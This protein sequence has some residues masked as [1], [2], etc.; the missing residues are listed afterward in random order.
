MSILGVVT[1]NPQ[2]VFSSRAT[3]TVSVVVSDPSIRR[4]LEAAI[5]D[6]GWQVETF[7]SAQEY[8]ARQCFTGPSCVILEVSLL[9]F[10]LLKRLADRANTRAILINGSG[11]VMSVHDMKM[12]EP[13]ESHRVLSAVRDAME[14]SERAVRREQQIEALRVCYDSLSA[15]EREVMALVVEGLLNKQVGHKLGLSEITVKA[16]R[17]KVMRKMKAPSL[18]ELVRMAAWLELSPGQPAPEALP[19]CRGAARS[20]AE[21]SSLAISIRDVGVVGITMA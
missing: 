6:S 19:A 7:A 3:Q 18:A 12:R 15:R 5:S 16:H 13:F 10:S 11:D 4:S 21:K 2:L 8:L 14:C 20:E 17:G 9:S 1:H